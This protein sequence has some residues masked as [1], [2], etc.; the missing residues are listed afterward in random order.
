MG[1]V[2]GFARC[3]DYFADLID[4]GVNLRVVNLSLGFAEQFPMLGVPAIPMA[5]EVLLHRSP[6]VRAGFEA[7]VERDVSIV[8]AAH[9]L[10]RDVDDAPEHA[11][12]PAAFEL[13]GLIGVGG[14]NHRGTWFGN[15]GRRTVDVVAPATD[16]ISPA[17][18]PELALMG[19]LIDPTRRMTGDTPPFDRLPRGEG[20][21]QATAYVSTVVALMR[22]HHDSAALDAAAI[23]R[24]L[25]ASSSPLPALPYMLL[26]R[27]SSTPEVQ[28]LL[29]LMLGFE[30]TTRNAKQAELEANSIAGAIVR[31]D[32]ALG[33]HDRTFARLTGPVQRQAVPVG[34]ALVIEAEAFDC[35][36][37]SADAALAAHVVSPDGETAPVELE[38]VGDGVF[39]AAFVVPQPGDYTIALDSRPDDVVQVTIE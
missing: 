17:I 37:P 39:R 14:I 29:Q 15:R 25:I 20:T 33:C 12:F 38:A 2:D 5:D 31:L 23:R 10:Y 28:T 22:A 32:G 24:R 19:R 4:R 3:L 9:N 30:P 36:R 34:E 7:L 13:P 26:L 21:S 16:V 8:A 11:M 18:A 6:A 35:E 1:T 27:E